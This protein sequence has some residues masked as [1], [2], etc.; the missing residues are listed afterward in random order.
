[1]RG[2]SHV[3]YTAI[4]RTQAIAGL[5]LASWLISMVLG[6]GQYAGAPL[7]FGVI[8]GVI[9]LACVWPF[10]TPSWLRRPKKRKHLAMM[11]AAH[12]VLPVLYGFVA[13]SAVVAADLADPL[14][15]QIALVIAALLLVSSLLCLTLGA[16]LCLRKSAPA[17]D[18]N[19]SVVTELV[20]PRNVAPQDLQGDAERRE[21]MSRAS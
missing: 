19:A 7:L 9:S 8:A 21:R 15:G 5:L 6:R 16:R 13:M 12:V 2:T 17:I 3:I 14:S 1:M 18:A 20:L 10:L 11:A 4:F